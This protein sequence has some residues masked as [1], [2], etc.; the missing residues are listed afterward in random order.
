VPH[1]EKATHHVVTRHPRQEVIMLTAYLAAAALC[2]ASAGAHGHMASPRG[3]SPGVN[4]DGAAFANCRDQGTAGEPQATWVEGQV[5]EIGVFISAFHQG[6]H[7]LR[8]H[9]RESVRKQHLLRINPPTPLRERHRNPRRT[10]GL[11]R[12]SAQRVDLRKSRPSLHSQPKGKSRD[13][14]FCRWKIAVAPSCRGDLQPLCPAVV[15]DHQ[16]LCLRTLQ[17]LPR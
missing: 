15:V 8:M 5:I 16:Q 10:G 13:L 11:P 9:L 17:V 2:V 1:P 12:R 3:R 4:G 14:I 6:W 7:E